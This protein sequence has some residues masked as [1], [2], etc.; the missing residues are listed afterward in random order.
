MTLG[1]RGEALP[2]IASVSRLEI[3]TR[4]PGPP[5]GLRASGRGRRQERDSALRP[6]ARDADRG[7]RPV[8]RDAGAAEVP[9][10]RSSR[11]AGRRRHRRGG[12]RWPPRTALH[13]HERHRRG[14]RLAGLRRGRSGPGRAA[15]A[16][17]GR[18]VRRQFARLR[19]GARRRAARGAL[20]LADLQQPE[21]AA[22]VRLRQRPGGAR[23]AARRARCAPPT[24]IFCRAIAM[25]WSRSS[26]TAI[27]ARSTSMSIRPRP[28]CVSAI[29]AW[30]AA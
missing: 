10:I 1:F 25:R 14:L 11:S 16:G 6:A 22:S 4:A 28:K 2:S 30:C 19:R 13:L 15:A 18:R 9:E 17:A 3:R 12:W 24:W 26:S 7:A 20:G 23:Q 21:C 5:L 29:P 8:R 27:R